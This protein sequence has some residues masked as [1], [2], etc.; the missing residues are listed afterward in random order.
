MQSFTFKQE[1]HICKGSHSI[2]KK[3]LVSFFPKKNKNVGEKA[4]V[5][6]VQGT[7]SMGKAK[8]EY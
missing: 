5:M 3:P 7:L 1:H 4:S 8:R 6:V 2:K